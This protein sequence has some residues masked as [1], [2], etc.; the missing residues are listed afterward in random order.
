MWILGQVQVGNA[1]K[2][3]CLQWNMGR[4]CTWVSP[5]FTFSNRSRCALSF[6]SQYSKPDGGY[7]VLANLGKVQIPHDYK[8]KAHI[9]ERS[10]DFKLSGFLINELGVATIFHTGEK[11]HPY[12]FMPDY[13]DEQM[14]TDNSHSRVLYQRARTADGELPPIRG[15]Q[16]RQK[17]Q[18]G[19]RATS[20]IE[21]VYFVNCFWWYFVR[22]ND[23]SVFNGQYV[24]RYRDRTGK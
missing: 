14:I 17:I 20:W 9:A 19:K 13:L 7:F 8:F 15:F 1:A 12:T 11:I 16:D 22:E 10:G 23:R 4:T 18:D 3:E 6:L 24:Y 5:I 2:N 21:G